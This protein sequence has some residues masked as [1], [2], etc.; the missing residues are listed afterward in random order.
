MDVKKLLILIALTLPGWLL[1]QNYA[2]YK[3]YAS[4]NFEQGTAE[5]N[6]SNTSMELKGARIVDDPVRGK[7]LSFDRVKSQYA[8]ITPAPVIGDTL[9]LSFWYKRSSFDSDGAWKQ[10]FEFYSSTNGS[11]IYLMPMYENTSSSAIVCDAKSFNEGVW[12]TLYGSQIEKNNTWHHIALVVAGVSWNYYLDGKKVGSRK[13]LSLISLLDLTHLYFGVNPDRSPYPSTGSI[14][15]VNI[16]HY[17][18]SASQVAQIYAGEA[19]TEPL[20]EGPITFLFDNDLKEEGGRIT[21]EGSGYSFEE[22]SQRGQV[23]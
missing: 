6:L 1:A 3:L 7:V 8:V 23:V 15:D 9:S 19:I 11:N 17:P 22:D 4:Y 16:Y 12:E 10:I 21:I 2:D 13:I 18:L 14:D 20:P 5:D